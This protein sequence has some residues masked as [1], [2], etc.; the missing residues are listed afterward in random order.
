MRRA[1]TEILK[2]AFPKAPPKVYQEKLDEHF[3]S[4]DSKKWKTFQRNL[5]S[6]SFV[7]AVIQDDRSDDKLKRFSQ[8]VNMHQTGK[9]PSVRV[10]SQTDGRWYTVKY[11]EEP[12]R[13]SCSCPDWTY[14][15]CLKKKG[16]CKHIDLVTSQLS[17]VKKASNA[18]LFKNLAGAGRA[19]LQSVIAE[20]NNEQAWHAGGIAKAHKRLAKERKLMSKI[21]RGLAAKSVLRSMG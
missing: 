6:K 16:N 4:T 3:S 13:W 15:Q 12:N 9:G 7:K 18:L 8:M 11:H 17:M 21:A 5:K 19:A 14:V 20:D 1:F 10:P 2:T